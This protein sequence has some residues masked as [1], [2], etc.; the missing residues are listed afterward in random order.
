M[1]F[2]IAAKVSGLADRNHVSSGMWRKRLR[3]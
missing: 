3:C 2:F 1:A